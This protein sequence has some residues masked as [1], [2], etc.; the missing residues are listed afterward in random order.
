MPRRLFITFDAWVLRNILSQVCL[1]R[2]CL[3]VIDNIL[4]NYASATLDIEKL[5]VR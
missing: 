4:D 3:C 2:G 5:V 1:P